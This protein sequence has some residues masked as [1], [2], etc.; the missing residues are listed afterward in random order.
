MDTTLLGVI[1]TVLA[2]N[3]VLLLRLSYQFGRYTERVDSHEA[4]I[5]SLENTRLARAQATHAGD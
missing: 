4:R 2:A 1:G 3:T 5:V